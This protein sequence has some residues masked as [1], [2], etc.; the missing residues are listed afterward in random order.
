MK[1]RIIIIA[2]LVIV[3]IA[4]IADGIY[5]LDETEQS[6]ITQFGD[7][8]GEPV[9][10][11]GMHFKIPFIQK[12]FVFD[13]RLLEWDGAPQEIPTK[14]NKFIH[15]DTFARWRISN[16]LTFY[17]SLK[18][19]MTAHSRLDDLLD[20]VVRDEIANHRLPE[21][22]RSSDRQMSIL[23]VEAVGV[24]SSRIDDLS[25]KGARKKISE[26]IVKHVQ[27]K[28]KELDLGIEV[29]DMKFKRIDYNPEVQ[30]KVFDRMVSGQKRIAE[31]YRAIGQGK[32]Q[33]IL[34]KQ[35]QRKKEILSK[36]Y[37]EAQTIRGK[38]DAKAIKIYADAYN[39]NYESRDFYN[40]MRTLN[41]YKFAM[42]T[43]TV[44]LLTTDNDFL[45]YLKSPK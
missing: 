30:E 4:F 42:D 14:D 21:I 29:I 27:D 18:N 43:T 38:A 26:S 31:K 35:D 33:D 8:V 11:A 20:G 2:I 24:D 44:L 39:K 17:K 37:L 23:E 40:F 9:I 3:V 32:K 36:A 15:I 6:I 22:I 34:G 13:K 10:K 12:V 19:E 1:T 25:I 5:I 7:P 41:A 28:L 16:A 45:K